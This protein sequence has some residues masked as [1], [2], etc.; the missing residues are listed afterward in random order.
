MLA[1]A[2]QLQLI[3]AFILTNLL[4]LLER[5]VLVVQVA[6]VIYTILKMLHLLDLKLIMRLVVIS[7]SLTIL[8]FKLMEEQLPLVIMII[9]NNGGYRYD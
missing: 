5:T 8:A 2:L 1:T 6:L 4:L 3:I 7:I 9:L